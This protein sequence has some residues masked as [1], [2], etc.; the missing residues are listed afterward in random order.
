MYSWEPP[1][2]FRALQEAGGVARHEMDRVFNMGVGLVL[3]VSP[4][5]AESIASR[6]ADGQAFSM[7]LNV[8]SPTSLSIACVII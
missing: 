5:Y 4:F 7:S 8:N 6:L 3:V 2:V 1:P